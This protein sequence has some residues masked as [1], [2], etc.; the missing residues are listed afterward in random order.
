MAGRGTRA[1]ER[2]EFIVELHDLVSAKMAGLSRRI[3]RFQT[4][5]RRAAFGMRMGFIVATA[6]VVGLIGVLRP[7]IAQ[8]RALAQVNTLGVQAR[9]LGQL[10]QASLRFAEQF[11]TAS[12]DFVSSAYDIQSAIANLKPEALV[13]FTRAAN[14]T[15][16]ATRSDAATMTDY[17]GTMYGIFHREAERLGK[18][19]WVRKLAGQTTMAVRL[20]K[21]TGAEL[22]AGFS[23]LGAQAE[24]LGMSLTTQLAVIGTLK[25][26]MSGEEAG[27]KF[28]RFLLGIGNAEQVLGVRLTDLKGRLLAL[29]EVLARLHKR[30]GDI[31]TVAKMDLLKKAF[32]RATAVQFV[33]LLISQ[34][35][36]IRKNIALIG[37]AGGIKTAEEAAHRGTTAF[38]RFKGSVEALATD[39]SMRVARATDPL[40]D[41]FSRGLH[42]IRGWIDALPNLTALVGGLTAAL[43]G[44]TAALAIL[45][46][47]VQVLKIAWNAVKI[48]SFASSIFSPWGLA[49]IGIVAVLVEVVKH[50]KQVKQ[51]GVEAATA[52]SGAWHKVLGW[53]EGKLK[54]LGDLVRKITPDWLQ[55]VVAP[56]TVTVTPSAMRAA[57]VAPEPQIDWGPKTAFARPPSPD[58]I[59]GQAREAINH[60][61]QG[62]GNRTTVVNIHTTKAPDAGM[63]HRTLALEGN[64]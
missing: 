24:S 33:Q 23:R 6:A 11:G 9:A 60:A 58:V 53:I 63:L 16:I 5:M 40:L 48:F 46:I 31:N 20:F 54:A 51:W 8:E 30:L 25:S 44:L 26:T 36:K 45:Y 7:A 15:A 19:N 43:F 38:D 59:R 27:T 18:A 13:A 42:T 34:T 12:A 62:G 52:I 50:W 57:G 64:G 21:T 3:T 2:L 61:A 1:L 39:F 49:L 10:S 17:F 14:L 22:A 35:D 37:K 41:K 28:E 47:V 55:R 32:G 29:P 56:A 4:A